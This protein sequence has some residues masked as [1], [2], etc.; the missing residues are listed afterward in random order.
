[1]NDKTQD[2]NK[3]FKTAIFLTRHEVLPDQIDYLEGFGYKVLT[4]IEYTNT[5]IDKVSFTFYS[6][7]DAYKLAC[8]IAGRPLSAQDLVIGVL[9]ISMTAEFLLRCPAPLLRANMIPTT[10]EK[11]AT[12]YTWTGVYNQT[13]VCEYLSKRWLPPL[14]EK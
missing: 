5:S 13:I 9:P 14:E 4:F 11:N 8:K 6:G 7:L 1:M 3:H 2:M 10:R 12:K